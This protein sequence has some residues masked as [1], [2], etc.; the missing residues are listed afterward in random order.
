MYL[1]NVNQFVLTG[2]VVLVLNS[3]FIIKKSVFIFSFLVQEKKL[4]EEKTLFGLNFYVVIK[5]AA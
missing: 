4:N 3:M 5:Y 2:Y 1:N